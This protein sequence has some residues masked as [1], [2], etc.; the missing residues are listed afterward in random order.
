[1]GGENFSETMPHMQ[2][3]RLRY[4]IVGV[5]WS[6]GWFLLSLLAGLFFGIAGL[7]SAVTAYLSLRALGAKARP[8]LAAAAAL[9]VGTVTFTVVQRLLVLIAP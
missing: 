1:M 6:D 3:K 8:A 7:F 5:H 2:N 9:V 4:W